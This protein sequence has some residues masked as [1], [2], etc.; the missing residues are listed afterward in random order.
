M[1]VTPISLYILSHIITVTVCFVTF[2]ITEEWRQI[3]YH[4]PDA[5]VMGIIKITDVSMPAIVYRNCYSRIS[6]YI[7]IHLCVS[8]LTAQSSALASACIVYKVLYS[9]LYQ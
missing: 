5:A 2:Q 6:E 8:C 1:H 9:Q 4:D 7:G 3:D